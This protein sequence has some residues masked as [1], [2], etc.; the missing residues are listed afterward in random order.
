MFASVVATAAGVGCAHELGT[1][2]V[3]AV[4]TPENQRQLMCE[5]DTPRNLF[6][7]MVTQQPRTACS[8]GAAVFGQGCSKKTF[9]IKKN[10]FYKY[11]K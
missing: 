4:T 5:Q 7:L 10:L 8:L 9:L 3:R 1:T 6:S 11:S 2:K